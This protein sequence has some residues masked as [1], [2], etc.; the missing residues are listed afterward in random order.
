MSFTKKIA[1]SLASIGLVAGGVV[2]AGA[3]QATS[4]Q[5]AKGTDTV[6]Q[7][8]V[9]SVVRFTP[10]AKQV[11]PNKVSFPGG[12]ITVNAEDKPV[13]D[14]QVQACGSG[15][16]CLY[17]PGGN[18]D[19]YYCGYYST[20]RLWGDGTFN[21]NQTWGTRARFYNSNGSERWSNVAK[22]TGTASWS[23]VYYVRPC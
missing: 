3:A 11:A 4:D 10:G 1:L 21:N 2:A 12:M 20:Y 9:D 6:L 19:F 16:L 22:D 13:T 7:G 8:K 15:H 23:P 17:S 14:A 5:S 18:Y